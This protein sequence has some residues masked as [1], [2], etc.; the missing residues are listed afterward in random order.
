MKKMAA[1]TIQNI[2]LIA[3]REYKSRVFKRGFAFGTGVLVLFALLIGF[4]PLILGL[5]S[6]ANAQT[7]VVLLNKAGNVAGQTTDALVSFLSTTLNAASA[8]LPTASTDKPPF[9]ITKAATD[10]QAALEQQV[11]DDK[12]ESV[13][14]ISRDASGEAV[15]SYT[16]KNSA[17]GNSVA[18][19]RQAMNS[20]AASDRLERA[21]LNAAQQQK[22]FAPATFT[23]ISTS[24]ETFNN[25]KSG[26][27]NGLSYIITFALVILLFTTITLYGQWIAQGVIEEKSSR[28]MEIMI[29]AAT[30][31]QLMYGKI[32]GIGAAGLSQFAIFVVAAVIGLQIQKLFGSTLG[33]SNATLDLGGAT[34]GLLV[35][36]V[37]FFLLGFAL[38]STLYAGLAS[39]VSRQEDLQGALAPLAFLNMIGYFIAIFGLQAINET[40]VKIA[41]FFPFFS[42]ILMIAR[43][44]V[45]QVEWWEVALAL[46]LM[47]VT[48]VL[49]T[50][51]AA[52]L[53]RNGILHY[54]TKQKLFSVL[55]QRQSGR[56][57]Q[58]ATG[59][60]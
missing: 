27:A 7:K 52:R 51:L 9:A 34:L 55:R 16:T 40:W 26:L 39:L 23:T 20:L 24:K 47:A 37:G 31:N 48:T 36:F 21:G 19:I 49:M 50:M 17:D 8:A 44:G 14:V 5:I 60:A 13:L 45:G 42:P 57:A 32:L 12:L 30:P 4:V 53:Y 59:Q 3:G 56:T 25:G 11:R 15:F 29:N 6:N 28:V 22:A 10:N 43:I 38:Y 46:V 35:A 2:R 33:V 58:P 54:G 18:Q 41:S 1:N